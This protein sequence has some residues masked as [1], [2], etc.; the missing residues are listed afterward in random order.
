M[1]TGVIPVTQQDRKSADVAKRLENQAHRAVQ[2]LLQG[3]PRLRPKGIGI[4]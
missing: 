4:S 3:Q 2:W 1:Q